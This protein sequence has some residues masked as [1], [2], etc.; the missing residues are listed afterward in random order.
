MGIDVVNV[1]ESGACNGRERER[2]R[3]R[4]R[5][6]SRLKAEVMCVSGCGRYSGV[7]RRQEETGNRRIVEVYDAQRK[8]L[9]VAISERRLVAESRSSRNKQSVGHSQSVVGHRFERQVDLDVEVQGAVDRHGSV[10]SRT[11]G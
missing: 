2:E 4:R 8:E 6:G 1:R 3:E 9:D 5:G 10:L 11:T 7:G